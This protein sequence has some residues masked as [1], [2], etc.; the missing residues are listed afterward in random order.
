MLVFYPLEYISF[1]SSPLAPLMHGISNAMSLKAQLWSIRAWGSYVA[2][3]IALLLSEWRELLG[4]EQA[5][6][7]D[8]AGD[9]A[10]KKRKEAIVYQL[11]ANISRLPVILHWCVGP[12]S[13]FTIQYAPSVQATFLVTGQ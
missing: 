2:F 3:Q 6:D 8:V 1:F 11:V 9:E 4:K 7:H 10:I 13:P 5:L 12:I